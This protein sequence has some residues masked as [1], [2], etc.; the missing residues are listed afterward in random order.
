MLLTK[1]EEITET[2]GELHMIA[3]VLLYLFNVKSTLL[4]EFSFLEGYSE[5]GQKRPSQGMV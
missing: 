1:H 5:K 3:K 4:Q 2:L